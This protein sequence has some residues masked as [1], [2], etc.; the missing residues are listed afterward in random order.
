MASIRDALL[1]KITELLQEE[2]P[3]RLYSEKILD[4]AEAYAWVS[5]PGHSHGG[6][7]EISQTVQK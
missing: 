7:T 3:A 5:T 2:N 1:E 4:L 6:R